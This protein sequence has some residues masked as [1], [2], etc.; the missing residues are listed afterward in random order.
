MKNE[1]FVDNLKKARADVKMSQR[2]VADKLK[3]SHGT[4]ASYEVGR[5]K[6]DT[7]TL[8]KIAKLYNVSVDWLLG[9]D[10]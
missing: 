8:I 1:I 6:P 4:I 10:K 7:T 9:I 3:I 2:E 5:T